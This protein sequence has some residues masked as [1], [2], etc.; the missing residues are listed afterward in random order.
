[1]GWSG[2]STRAPIAGTVIVTWPSGV[3]LGCVGADPLE[4]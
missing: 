3:D 2:R 4:A 1:M